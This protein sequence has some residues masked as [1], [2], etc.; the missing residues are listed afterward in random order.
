MSPGHPDRI[1]IEFN[2]NQQPKLYFD[3]LCQE[4]VSI[5]RKADDSDW[6]KIAS[7]VRSPFTDENYPSGI[8]ELQYRIRYGNPEQQSPVLTVR[9]P[10]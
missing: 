10:D 9:M 7:G 8:T 4:A 6:Q 2:E 3:K 5:E 1:R